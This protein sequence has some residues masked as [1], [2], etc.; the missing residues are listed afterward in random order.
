MIIDKLKRINAFNGVLIFLICAGVFSSCI[1]DQ[2]IP[3]TIK[4]KTKP[5]KQEEQL[6]IPKDW[7]V[8]EETYEQMLQPI[9]DLK[10]SNP[11]I[12][13]FI[14]SWLN[15]NY[16]TPSWEGY[17]SDDWQ[18]KTKARGIDCSGFARVMQDK[19]FNKRIRGGSQGILDNYC[20]PKDSSTL[21][22]G[23]L[24]FFKA[25]H[26]NNERIVHVGVY[27]K[28]GFFVHATS[29]K[30]AAKGMGLR[31]S[32]LDEKFWAQDFIAGGEVK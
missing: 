29:P 20:V 11:D 3:E 5:V 27:L 2:K 21:I 22:M 8:L 31:I 30:S 23:D 6:D 15:T 28:N 25:R 9:L 4:E 1:T 32:S 17:N 12:Y 13:W 26:S 7:L 10:S 14:V 16:R 24:V 19:I 18:D